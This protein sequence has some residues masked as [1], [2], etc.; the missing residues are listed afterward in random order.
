M[1]GTIL[2][3]QSLNFLFDVCDA[4][5]VHNILLHPV[6]TQF[7]RCDPILSTEITFKLNLYC[8]AV[9]D[10]IVPGCNSLT[11]SMDFLP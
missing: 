2:V 4:D 10:V 9:F 1:D 5:L 7:E 11:A 8:K 6:N 3:S